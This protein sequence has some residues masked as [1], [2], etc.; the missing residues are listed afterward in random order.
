[1]LLRY[2]DFGVLALIV[3][4]FLLILMQSVRDKRVR[5]SNVFFPIFI[6]SPFSTSLLVGVLF[7]HFPLKISLKTAQ[8]T[9]MHR[10]KCLIVHFRGSFQFQQNP[11]FFSMFNFIPFSS[12]SCPLQGVLLKKTWTCSRQ[13]GIWSFVVLFLFQGAAFFV[14]LRFLSLIQFWY[15]VEIVFVSGDR[16]IS[17]F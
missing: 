10:E 3:S 15:L 4:F 2:S 17:P 16:S 7:H 14:L 12:I 8:T 6:T 5:K 1:M 11:L 9:V 13:R